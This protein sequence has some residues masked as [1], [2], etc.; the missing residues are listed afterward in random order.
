MLLGQNRRID[1]ILLEEWVLGR[2]SVVAERIRLRRGCEVV[3][4]KRPETIAVRM[5]CLRICCKIHALLEGEVGWKRPIELSV[6][7]WVLGILPGCLLAAVRPGHLVR[8]FQNPEL[9]GVL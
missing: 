6:E 9:D 1:G 8:Q 5:R 3:Q 7:S 4:V 2:K